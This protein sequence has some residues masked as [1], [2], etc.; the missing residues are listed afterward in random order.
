MVLNLFYIE[1]NIISYLFGINKIF[2]NIFSVFFFREIWM[3]T[4]RLTLEKLL[5]LIIHYFEMRLG[6]NDKK[7]MQ[8]RCLWRFEKIDQIWPMDDI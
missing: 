1:L 4:Y 7:Y 5:K 8:I 6:K 3:R 2:S